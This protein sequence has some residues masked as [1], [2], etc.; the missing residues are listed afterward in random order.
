MPGFINTCAYCNSSYK[1]GKS[2]F[3]LGVMVGFFIVSLLILWAKGLVTHFI[4]IPLLIFFSIAVL[5]AWPYIIKLIIVENDKLT[6]DKKFFKPFLRWQIF[7]TSFILLF[8]GSVVYTRYFILTGLNRP[9]SIQERSQL[10]VDYLYDY[11][12]SSL[13]L[14]R[15]LFDLMICFSVGLIALIA[16]NYLFYIKVRGKSSS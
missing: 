5:Y 7:I 1:Q 10:T 11:L 13:D 6:L 2:S 16:F 4:A 12:I 9:F 14:Q 15:A 3:L 8:L